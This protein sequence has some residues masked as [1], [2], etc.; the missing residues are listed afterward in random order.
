MANATQGPPSPLL[1]APFYLI[2][3]VVAQEGHD[4]CVAVLL[5]YGADATHKM[6]DGD[7]AF[8]KAEAWGRDDC[9]DVLKG[10]LPPKHSCMSGSLV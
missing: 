4:E 8:D 6:A 1:P 10:E 3:V 9:V 7:T 2:F 5:A